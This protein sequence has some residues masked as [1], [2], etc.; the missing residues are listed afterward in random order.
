MNPLTVGVGSKNPSKVGAVKIMMGAY[1]DR[2]GLE[3]CV[4]VTGYDVP[5]G[6]PP[7]P[8][9]L[10]DIYTGACNRAREVMTRH[11]PHYAVGIEAGIYPQ[12]VHR[13][14]TQYC[15]ILDREGILTIGHSG[16]FTYPPSVVKEVE[17]GKEI[18]DI[19]ATLSGTED[20]KHR[21]G[22]I[23]MLSKGW[24]TRTE[25]SCQSVQMALIPRFGVLEDALLL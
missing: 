25:F 6:V 5:S 14:D 21:E 13:I 4:D 8:L 3:G 16:G 20:I 24:I 12:G 17:K 2:A 11:R 22:A 23:G 19:F 10:D 9:S 18:G 7:Q 1:A 15:A